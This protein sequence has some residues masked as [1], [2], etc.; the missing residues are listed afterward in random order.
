M[1]GV[2]LRPAHLPDFERPPLHEVVLGVQFNAPAK[3]QQ[4]FAGD[5]WR[6]FEKDYP[7]VEEKPALAPAFETFGGRSTAQ[8]NIGF[9]S[10]AQHDRFWFLSPKKDELIQFQSDRLLHNWRKVGDGSNPYPRFER[11]IDKFQSELAALERYINT[12]APQR[13]HINQCEVTYVNHIALT[14]ARNPASWIGVLNMSDYDNQD[15]FSISLRHVI[16]GKDGKPRGRLIIAAVSAATDTGEEI[17]KLELTMRG[18]PQT[19]QIDDAV[20]FLLEGRERIVRKFADITTEDAQKVWE[21]I[22]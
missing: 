9:L 16:K 13:L 4:I 8:F 14:D 11:M 17:I 3:Y 7:N 21:R 12:L 5:V 20:A 22:Q 18:A 15:D 1:K 10:G 2:K 6:L 19:S